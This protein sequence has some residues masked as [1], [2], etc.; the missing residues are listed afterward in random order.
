MP[1]LRSA[2]FFVCPERTCGTV[3]FQ[4]MKKHVEQKY[5]LKSGHTGDNLPFN[6][7][8]LDYST[9][10]SFHTKKS[11][12]E[13]NTELQ[14][15]RKGDDITVQQVF[16][17]LFRS[18]KDRAMHK[19]NV[20]RQ[21]KEDGIEFNVKATS[22]ITYVLE[23]CMELYKDRTWII[24]LRRNVLDHLK[25]YAVWYEHQKHMSGRN[26]DWQFV[27][28]LMNRKDKIQISNHSW[29]HVGI[30]FEE[31]YN[32]YGLPDMLDANHIDY[33]VLYYEDI[34]DEKT[35]HSYINHM[36]LSDAWNKNQPSNIDKIV[37]KRIEKDYENIMKDPERFNRRINSIVWP[38]MNG[39]LK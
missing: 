10:Y 36:F 13:V 22:S 19:V 6:D 18:K 27:E 20:L 25:S 21:L 28:R 32:I 7:F 9:D 30:F 14:L 33:Q 5:N 35:R 16:P 26:V 23:E 34:I 12:E 17:W 31:L 11:A 38:E 39:G 8:F 37:P 1:K 3:L 15:V 24:T 29:D 2:P 4:E